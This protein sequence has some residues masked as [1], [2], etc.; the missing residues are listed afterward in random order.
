M[1]NCNEDIIVFNFERWNDSPEISSV[2][3]I[4]MKPVPQPTISVCLS[5]CLILYEYCSLFSLE[6]QKKDWL[7]KKK[8]EKKEK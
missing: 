4:A 3:L 6:A 2:N 8:K 7:Q 5:V 1:A